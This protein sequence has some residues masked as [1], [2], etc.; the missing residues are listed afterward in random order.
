MDF[1]VKIS[2]APDLKI[3]FRFDDW[4]QIIRY[5]VVGATIWLLYFFVPIV[6][7]LGWREYYGSLTNDLTNPHSAQ[8]VANLT[9]TMIGM[10]WGMPFGAVYEVIQT[11][12]DIAVYLQFYSI[13]HPISHAEQYVPILFLLF[14]I[15]FVVSLFFFPAALFSYL[16]SDDFRSISPATVI[17]SA[18]NTNYVISWIVTTFLWT[19]VLLGQHLWNDWRASPSVSSVSDTT[20]VS[21]GVI[22]VIQRPTVVGIIAVPSLLVVSF[23]A[24]LLLTLSFYYMRSRWEGNR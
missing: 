14:S 1:L 8:S 3:E 9:Y 11:L 13:I 2:Q 17:P 16:D 22:P 7:W 24:F 19:I 5:G 20:F 6:F 15:S 23:I 10:G 21:I 18:L 4:K 12:K